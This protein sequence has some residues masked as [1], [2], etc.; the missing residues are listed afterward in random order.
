MEEVDA[1]LEKVSREGIQ[2]LT[3]KEREILEKA[4]KKSSNSAFFQPAASKNRPPPREAGGVKR[5]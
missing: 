1:V 3:K 5:P 4:L 2:N